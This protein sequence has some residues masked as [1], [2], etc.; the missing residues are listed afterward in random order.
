MPELRRQRQG[1]RARRRRGLRRTART[2]RRAG[3]ALAVALALPGVGLLAGGPARAQREQGYL[4]AVPRTDAATA[5]L[6][7]TVLDPVVRLGQDL[8]DLGIL[9]RLRTVDS[10]A[11]NPVGGLAQGTDAS[12][13]VIFGADADLGRIAGLRG[14]LVH[15]TFA[16]FYGHELSSDVIGARTKV[17]SYYYPYKQFEMSELTYEQR[18]L[19]DRLDVT[20]GRANGTGTFARSTYGCRFQTVA[21]CPFELTQV[22]AGLPGFPYSNWGGS[23]RFD[24]TRATYAQA[25]AYEVNPRRQH[26]SGFDWGLNRSTGVVV[27]A[28]IGYATTFATDPYPRHLKFGG[29][30]NSADYT[31]PY[32]NARGRSRALFG[33]APQ[34]Y[35]GGRGGLYAL[36]DQVVYRHDARSAR[37]VA[38]FGSVG[39]PFDGKELFALQAVAG[40][41]WTGPFDARPGDQIGVLGT[42]LRLTN[43]EVGYLNDLL[44]HARSPDRLSRNEFIAEVNYGFR[45][46][47][48]VY[49]APSVQVLLNPDLINKPNAGKTP[50]NALVAGLK[51]VVNGNELLGLPD[52]LPAVRVRGPATD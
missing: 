47:P 42:Y 20:V 44:A 35:A 15:A 29:W 19:G 4:P 36:A 23:V 16:Q 38:V 39:G 51:L 41:L 28:E 26:E 49:L 8:Y 22:V 52:T 14:G 32:L 30:Y 9:P 18:L 34:G 5:P 46:V 2:A 40:A 31:D 25:G 27:P 1:H 3:A 37:G 24:P 21:D 7:G 12:G 48:G 17:Q 6:N 50:R 45:I 33:G 10:F 43:A 13:V 11:A